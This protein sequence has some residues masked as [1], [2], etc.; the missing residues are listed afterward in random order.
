MATQSQVITE[1]FALYVISALGMRFSHWL[2]MQRT[3]LLFVITVQVDQCVATLPIEITGGQKT[4][5]AVLGAIT[6]CHQTGAS[7]DHLP[8]R[9]WLAWRGQWAVDVCC[10]VAGDHLAHWLWRATNF[11]YLTSTGGPR[12]G[13]C[14]TSGSYYSDNL[15][16]D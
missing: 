1:W 3:V 16:G 5:M 4:T 14:A 13:G 11:S 6:T 9:A 15:D 2:V 7:N 12:S 10:F 8:A